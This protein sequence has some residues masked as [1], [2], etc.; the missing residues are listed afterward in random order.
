VKLQQERQDASWK[1]DM[2][3]KEAD[4]NI[5]LKWVLG[6]WCCK[7]VDQFYLHHNYKYVKHNA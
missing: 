4:R 2:E 1:G 7:E 5:I 6:K 3:D